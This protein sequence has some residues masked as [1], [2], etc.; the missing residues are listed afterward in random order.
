[1]AEIK[2]NDSFDEIFKDKNNI[3]VV[4]AHP[5]DN[6]II[7][8]GLV[9]RLIDKGKKIRLIVTTTGGKGFQNRTDITEDEFAKLRFTEQINAGLELGISKDQNFNLGIPDGEMENSLS[10]IEKLVKHI[11]EFKPDIIITHNPQDMINSFS[12]D[13]KWVNHRDHRN[14]AMTVLDAAYPYSRDRGFFPEHFS[15]H[16]LT[17]HQVGTFLFSDYFMNPKVSYF[18]I[19]N[20][21]SQKEASLRSHKN[22]LGDEIDAFMEEGIMG[23]GKT[24]ERLLLV[25]TD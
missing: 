7:C 21:R 12:E 11:R 13:I 8:G 24:Y 14:T 5:D 23:D 22:A 1:M 2:I 4:T 19:T 3:L 17:P 16:G 9:A 18:D 15:K 25:K 6:E 20:Y 10:N